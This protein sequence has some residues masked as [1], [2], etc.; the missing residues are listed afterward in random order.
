MAMFFCKF[1]HCN[2]NLCEK[3]DM[4]EFADAVFYTLCRIHVMMLKRLATRVSCDLLV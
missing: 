4:M 2:V 3:T 1:Q